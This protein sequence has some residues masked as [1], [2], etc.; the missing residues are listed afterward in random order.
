LRGELHLRL[1]RASAL[2]LAQQFV[3]EPVDENKEFT[4]E[5]REAV[6]ELLR[7]I[8]GQ[9]AVS[10]NPRWGEVSIRTELSEA[11]A[12]PAAVTAMLNGEHEQAPQMLLELRLSAAL[13]AAL[14]VIEPAVDA[15]ETAAAPDVRASLG[16]LMDVELNVSLRFGTRR[17]LLS[18]ILDLGAGAV[19]ELDR[20]TDEPVDLLL[21]G[22]LV[23]RGE[24]VVIDGNFGLRVTELG[25]LLQP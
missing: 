11:P 9:V 12:W 8:A 4:A 1:P 24:V 20:H 13:A 2:R 7:Q 23:A 25:A 16:S 3:G 22:K 5:N 21:D 6:E 14:R 18:D 17:M 19:V 10:C 15:A